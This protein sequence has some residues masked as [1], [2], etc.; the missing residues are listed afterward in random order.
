MQNRHNLYIIHKTNNFNFNIHSSKLTTVDKKLKELVE[1]AA[2]NL[3]FRKS[4]A[5]TTQVTK[6]SQNPPTDVF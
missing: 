5:T 4:Q 2:K 6:L 1:S 3:F